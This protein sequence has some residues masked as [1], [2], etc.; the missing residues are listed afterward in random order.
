M[1]DA[2]T[3]SDEE[4]AAI[5]QKSR[6]ADARLDTVISNFESAKAKLDEAV[7]SELSVLRDRLKELDDRLLQSAN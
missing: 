5:L 2:Y 4:W 7:E 3:A 6:D 1:K